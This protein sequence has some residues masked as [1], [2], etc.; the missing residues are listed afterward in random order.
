M[1]TA[2]HPDARI[3][4]VDDQDYNLRLLERV[5]TL[6]GYTNFRS[7]NDPRAAVAEFPH[8]Q[9]DLILLDLLMPHLAGIEVMERLQPLVPPDA[10]LPI[11]I[12]T[13]DIN[14]ESKRRALAAGARDFLNKPL[15]N[16]EVLLRI[17]N[18]LETRFLYRQLQD[19]N[20]ALELTVRER[21]RTLA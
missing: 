19:Q 10:Y 15:D 1:S 9:P 18:L 20:Q 5:L 14:P 16:L 4:I 11:L 13:A 2:S 3:L 7:L 17:N 12:L 21:T 6:G 8:Y